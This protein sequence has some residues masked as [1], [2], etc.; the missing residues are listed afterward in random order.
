MNR[1][2][3]IS[4][5]FFSGTSVL[6]ITIA[7]VDK[8]GASYYGEQTLHYICTSGE[9]SLVQLGQ[10]EKLHLLMRDQ[11]FSRVY[12]HKEKPAF[13]CSLLSNSLLLLE[14]VTLSLLNILKESKTKLKDSKFKTLANRFSSSLELVLVSNSIENEFC[15]NIAME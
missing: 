5:F 15:G 13:I 10:I 3:P 2:P 4:M 12:N 14:T 9:S 6:V 1:A 8:S 11:S 7:D